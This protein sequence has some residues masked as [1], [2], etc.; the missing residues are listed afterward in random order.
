[1]PRGRPKGFKSR[2]NASSK[3][4]DDAEDETMKA[5]QVSAENPQRDEPDDETEEEVWDLVEVLS[6]KKDG[7][8]TTCRREGCSDVAVAAWATN[9]ATND[10]WNV[11][12]KCQVQEFGGWPEGVDPPSDEDGDSDEAE[13]EPTSTEAEAE[14]E[15]D[16]DEKGQC[17]ASGIE[18][19][20]KNISQSQESAKDGDDS[21][22][23]TTTIPMVIHDCPNDVR[24]NS[25]TK[26]VESPINTNK[27]N[28]DALPKIEASPDSTPDDDADGDDETADEVW[29]LK[30]I[31]PIE[32]VTEECPILCS[33]ED[34][35]L[36]AC[37]IWISNRAPTTKW[38]CCLDC[39]EDDFD[40]WPPAEEL[41]LQC[42]TQEHRKAI[43]TKSSRQ[44][45]PAM[46][47]LPNSTTPPPGSI[48][49]TPGKPLA[50]GMAHFVTP[51][52]NS[53]TAAS[54]DDKDYDA[55]KDAAPVASKPPSANALAA[56]KKW[57]EEAAKRGGKDARIVVSKPAAKRLIFNVLLNVFRP[58]NITEI[59][60]VR[61]LNIRIFLNLQLLYFRLSSSTNILKTSLFLTRR[62]RHS[63][64]MRF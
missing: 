3:R 37:C 12:E 49:C 7:S 34:C 30:K 35:N 59:Y 26:S 15:R 40:G 42:M 18:T 56:H 4:N 23:D 19:P 32:A 62:S 31:L 11:C 43:A 47:D 57:Q 20:A 2:D 29:D 64:P 38:Y 41:P 25:P 21:K 33:T 52:P 8:T 55:S 6:R 46:P 10:R 60:E 50:D 24:D 27:V 13:E 1:M 45:S 39:Q 5:S 22:G 51:P 17:E 48:S 36:T 53:L 9:L 63:S 61:L 44:K 28:N 16:S 14:G 54:V 58:M